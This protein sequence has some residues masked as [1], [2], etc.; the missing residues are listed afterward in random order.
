[1]CHCHGQDKDNGW[2]YTEG[3]SQNVLCTEADS[4]RLTSP[5]TCTLNGDLCAVDYHCDAGACELTTC[6]AD[7]EIQDLC[8]C[9]NEVKDNGWCYTDGYQQYVKCQNDAEINSMCHCHGVDKDD[10]LCHT[11]GWS[12]YDYCDLDTEI[13]SMCHCHGQ[14]ADNGWCYTDG[15]LQYEKCTEAAELTYKSQ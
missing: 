9:H 15:Y 11:S 5:C 8:M 7:Q 14:D 4:V 13:N 2:C 3:Y 12:S 6:D 10:G 1:M